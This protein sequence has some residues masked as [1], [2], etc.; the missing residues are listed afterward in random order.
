MPGTFLSRLAELFAQALGIAPEA[1]AAFVAERCAG[2]PALARELEALLRSHTRAGNFLEEP[3]CGAAGA[4]DPGEPGT[5]AF[6]ERFRV[7]ELLGAGAMGT[8]YRAEQ[9]APVRREVALKVLAQELAGA[10]AQARFQAE[11]QAVAMLDHPHIAH[12]YESATTQDGRP[13]FAME[14]VRGQPIHTFCSA[15]RLPLAARVALLAAVCRAV[16]HA[17]QKGVVHRDL[18]PSN[19]LV[20][21]HGGQPVPK[22]IDFGVAKALAPEPGAEL[23]TAHG[24]ILG[25]L[26]Y[27]SP[28]QAGAAPDVDTRADIYSLGVMLYELVTNE[29]PFASQRLRG[30]PLA[31]A[32]RIVREEDPPAPSVRAG[33][34]ALR[35]LDWIVLRAM[36][37]DRARRYASAAEVAED[38]ERFLRHEPLVARPVT[39]SYRFQKLLRR[40][41]LAAGAVGAVLLTLAAGVVATLRESAHAREQRDL[42]RES[43]RKARENLRRAIDSVSFS[44][45][46]LGES[47]HNIAGAT[48]ARRVQAE[49]ALR[50]FEQLAALPESHGAADPGLGYAWQRYGEV[51]LAQGES[52]AALESFERSLAVRERVL[53]RIAG[54]VERRTLAVGLWRRAQ[55]LAVRGRFVAAEADCAR[56]LALLSDLY[57]AGTPEPGEESIYLGIALRRVAEH[58]HWEGRDD[59]ARRGLAEAVQLLEAGLR[60]S[61]E[62]A[63]LQLEHCITLIG[64]AE[65]R[66]AAGESEAARAMLV[67]AQESLAEQS[68]RS[69]RANIQERRLL[70]RCATV[71][72]ALAAREGGHAAALAAARRAESLCAAILAADPLLHEV[73]V[74]HA[75][76]MLA[77]ARAH[78]NSGRPADVLEALGRAVA[79]FTELEAKD[80]EH[81][82]VRIGR[83]EA[84]LLAARAREAALPGDAGAAVEAR[85]AATGERTRALTL[86]RE[87]DAEGRLPA[88]ARAVLR[89]AERGG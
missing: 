24:E 67:R 31:E 53:A 34:R 47:L 51:Q 1:R 74:Q 12:L 41:R 21:E 27:M 83:A 59:E 15:R 82:F 33:D 62:H 44:V 63:P 81:V 6:E 88:G 35:E 86:L 78:A 26:E 14:L 18:K 89:A 30:V 28:E 8:V 80:P 85:A 61:P 65:L 55:A 16:H 64:L 76:A 37:K 29:L 39:A 2:E 73:R 40:H 56:A 32:L 48:A 71:E 23:A 43:E 75:E 52:A 79:I 9:L 50:S 25:T 3:A 17:H 38:L 19:V 60:V 77:G 70:A 58:R 87:L 36:E 49:T 84:S 20:A 5:P 45:S 69:G 10:A 68:A 57:A 72:A 22:V 46:F 7:L 13:F 66:G 42:A 4:A 54:H 11:Q